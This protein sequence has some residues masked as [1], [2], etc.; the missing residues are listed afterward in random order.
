[1]V[2]R[3]PADA[4]VIAADSG[5]DHALAA[6]LQPDLVVGDLDSVSPEGLAWAR[7]HDVP[8]DAYPA[9]KDMTDTEIALHAAA[10][11]EVDAVL[12]LAGEGDRLDHSLSAITSLG[13]ASMAWC[14]HIEARWGRALL[15]VVRGPSSAEF[16]VAAGT[17]FSLLALHGDCTGV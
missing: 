14:E 9:D 8:V 11:A 13:H 12:L 2:S 10:A 16:D 1:A 17:T 3:L 7:Q 5:L 15:R 6:G 4:F